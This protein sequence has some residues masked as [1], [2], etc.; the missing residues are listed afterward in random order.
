[1][2]QVHIVTR[3]LRDIE[4]IHIAGGLDD[5]NFANLAGL[6]NTHLRTCRQNGAQPRLILDC[7]EVS[8]IGS[9]ELNA[10]LEL[11]QLARAHGGDIKC[12]QLAPTIEQVANLIAS[13]DPLE[14]HPAVSSALD[15]FHS[16]RVTA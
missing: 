2:H 3:Q 14:C 7:A 13:G 6:L 9:V 16:S 11:A 8:Y 12:A 10:L 1:M 4:I 5:T 15:A